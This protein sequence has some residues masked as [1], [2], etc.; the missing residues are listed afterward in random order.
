M[1]AEQRD[2]RI[3]PKIYETTKW[4][5]FIEMGKPYDTSK[6]IV[7]ETYKKVKAMELHKM[8]G[9]KIEMIAELINP[10]VFILSNCL[11]LCL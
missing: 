2:I 1:V 8:T 11:E 6:Q 3:Q 7:Y 9:S 4:E 10:M 5:D